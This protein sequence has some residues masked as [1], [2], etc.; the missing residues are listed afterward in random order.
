MDFEKLI[1]SLSLGLVAFLYFKI[2]KWWLK[3]RNNNKSSSK[4]ITISESFQDWVIIISLSITSI[5]FL[6]QVF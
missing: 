2:H 5:I 4:P 1:I 6:I 3:E